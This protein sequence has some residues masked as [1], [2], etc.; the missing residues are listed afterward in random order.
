M[1]SSDSAFAAAGR[2]EAGVDVDAGVGVAI[3]VV[4]TADKSTKYDMEMKTDSA[5]VPLMLAQKKYAIQS[6]SAF[7]NLYTLMGGDGSMVQWVDEE[8]ARANKDYTH[9]NFRGA[10]DIAKMIF[11]QIYEGYEKYKKNKTKRQANKETI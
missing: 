1:G 10:K 4:S 2:V 8:P 11:N 5:V 6:E 7:V 3:L 9:F